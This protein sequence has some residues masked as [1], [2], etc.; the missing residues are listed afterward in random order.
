MARLTHR[1]LYMYL[2][3]G[4]LCCLPCCCQVSKP[5]LLAS[6]MRIAS[7]VARLHHRSHVE[8]PDAGLAVLLMDHT[9]ANK[10]CC[11]LQLGA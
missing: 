5:V 11:C 6:L 1:L 8:E 3:V 9:L 7:G 4:G 2:G 10:V